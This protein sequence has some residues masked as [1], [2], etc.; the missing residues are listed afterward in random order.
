[1]AIREHVEA[2]HTAHQAH[3]DCLFPGFLG[4][5]QNNFDERL[6]LGRVQLEKELGVVCPSE[7][8]WLLLELLVVQMAS[9][10]ALL[11][12]LSGQS[13]VA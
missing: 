12:P 9:T 1:M 7:A 3:S 4:P 10:G 2:N 5:A 11:S 8:I 13:F 6:W